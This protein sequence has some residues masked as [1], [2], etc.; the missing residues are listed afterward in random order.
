MEMNDA[1]IKKCFTILCNS[2]QNSPDFLIHL[3]LLCKNTRCNLLLLRFVE[4]FYSLNQVF[5]KNVQLSRWNAIAVMDNFYGLRRFNTSL[6]VIRMLPN[7]LF[8]SNLSYN[9]QMKL[10]NQYIN[11]ICMKFKKQLKNNY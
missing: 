8:N 11:Q 6:N 7:G 1:E 5:P 10:H 9:E 3:E 2:N 4:A